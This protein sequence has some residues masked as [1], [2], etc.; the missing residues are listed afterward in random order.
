MSRGEGVFLPNMS[1]SD[2]P[3]PTS[4]LSLAE[5]GLIGRGGGGEVARDCLPLIQISWGYVRSFHIHKMKLKEGEAVL[6]AKTATICPKRDSTP[7]PPK[8]EKNGMD[9]FQN[10]PHPPPPE[11]GVGGRHHQNPMS[12]ADAVNID[13]SH[14]MDPRQATIV[15]N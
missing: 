8:P 6:P 3:P 14:T 5:G 11:V 7:H 10:L 2:L 12:V 9:K 1:F 4:I 15:G 13:R